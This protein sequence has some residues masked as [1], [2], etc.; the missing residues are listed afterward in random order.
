MLIPPFAGVGL[1]AST[2]TKATSPARCSCQRLMKV[3]ADYTARPYLEWSAKDWPKTYQTP[4]YRN[5]FA[6]GI[7]FA[8]P[9][10]ISKPMQSANGTRSILPHRAPACLPPPW[11]RLLHERARHDQRRGKADAHRI[12]G[13]NGRSLRCLHRLAYSQGNCCNHDRIPVV[14]DYEKYPEFGRDIDLTFG[15]IGLAGHWMKYLLHHTFI[16]Q[17]KLRPGW[18]CCRID[19]LPT[20]EEQNMGNITNKE[21]Y[22]QA[23]Y[24]PHRRASPASCGRASF[25]N[26][27]DCGVN[28]KM[29]QL[30]TKSHH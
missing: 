5:I 8:V 18:S 24:P 10:L 3:D 26:C 20:Y 12:D 27:T 17:A 4:S 6:V 1:K 2:K 9:H 25:G 14:P 11:P 7:A 23:Y 28:Y 21:P 19:R 30:L 22:Q 15:E 16:Y 29:I 13:G